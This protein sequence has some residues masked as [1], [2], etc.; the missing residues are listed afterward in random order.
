MKSMNKSLIDVMVVGIVFA[1]S[2]NV[3]KAATAG[4]VEGVINGTDSNGNASTFTVSGNSGV[5][6]NLQE[7][8]AK[9]F[10]LDAEKA[11]VNQVNQVASLAIQN[12]SDISDLKTDVSHNTYDIQKTQKMV[13]DESLARSQAITDLDNQKVSKTTYNQDKA[14]QT[15]TDTN[16]NNSIATNT[17]DIA[18]HETVLKDLVTINDVQDDRLNALENAPKPKNGVDGKD[19]KNGV[20]GKDG[21]TGAQGVQGV[22]GLKGDTGAQ[23]VAGIAGKDGANGKDGK[24]GV[25]GKAGKDGVNGTNG[26]DGKNG[27]NGKNGITTTI[28][29]ADTAT[30]NAVKALKTQT[31]AQ[32]QDL[33]AAQQVFAQTQ[34]NNNAQFKSLKDEVDSNKKEARSGAASAV[35]I[36]SMPQVEKDQA[37]MFSAGVGSFKDEQAVSAGASFHVGSNTI[38]KAG[39]SDSTNNDFAMGAG[40]GIGF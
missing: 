23:G 18:K 14:D 25:D 20:D 36:A 2:M 1:A 34:A 6:Y 38:I 33:K 29:K 22:Q 35:A 40:I 17:A 7:Q 32:A 19:G 28:T 8:E 30:I 31:S 3:A 37:V 24:N 39:I 13:A 12:N 4:D 16:Q 5:N 21:A 10:Q 26:K 27:V 11:D 15:T 9:I